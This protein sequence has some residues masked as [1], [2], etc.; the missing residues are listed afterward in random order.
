MESDAAGLQG[1]V[2][3]AEE[4][5]VSKDVL[6]GHEGVTGKADDDGERPLVC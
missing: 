4:G 6:V 2:I 5:E 3:S 1:A